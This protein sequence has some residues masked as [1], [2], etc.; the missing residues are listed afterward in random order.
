MEF[1]LLA[2]VEPQVAAEF[3]RALEP[4]N[5][6]VQESLVGLVEK[7]C[8]TLHAVLED[9][10]LKHGV[11]DSRSRRRRIGEPIPVVTTRQGGTPTATGR[12]R[13]LCGAIIWWRGPCRIRAA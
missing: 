7:D 3:L 8:L 5:V 11:A 1:V 9:R 6:L 12:W 10:R 4:P 13:G 2:L